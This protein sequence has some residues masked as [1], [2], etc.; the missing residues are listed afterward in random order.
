MFQDDDQV[1]LDALAGHR[2]PRVDSAAAREA[3][4]LRAGILAHAAEAEVDVPA[5]DAAREQQL[6]ERARR[7]GLLPQRSAPARNPWLAWFGGWRAGLAVAGLAGMAIVIGVNLRP[8]AEPEIV[9]SSPMGV[10]RLEDADPLEL[11]RRLVDELRAAGVEAV[12]YERVGLRGVDADLPQPVPPRIREVLKRHRIPL[13]ADG[14]LLLEIA[15][16][17]RP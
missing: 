10:V 16:P 3:E 12:A 1:W 13:P 4:E 11:Q 15:E 6:I 7:A 17:A 5:R 14:V 2:G 9:R 8:K